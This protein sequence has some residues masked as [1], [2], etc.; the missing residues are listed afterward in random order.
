MHA[1]HDTL[2]KK[3]CKRYKQIDL[4]FQRLPI[5][6]RFVWA[7]AAGGQARSKACVGCVVHKGPR[8]QKALAIGKLEWVGKAIV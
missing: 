4:F 2:D 5:T 1:S 3:M 7:Y 6:L 8:L